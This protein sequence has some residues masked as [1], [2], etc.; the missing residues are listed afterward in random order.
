VL[1]RPSNRRP[2][3]R[4]YFRRTVVAGIWSISCLCKNMRYPAT[5]IDDLPILLKVFQLPG[6]AL[7][8]D[9]KAAISK[10]SYEN[11]QLVRRMNIEVIARADKKMLIDCSG[12]NIP[13]EISSAFEAVIAFNPKAV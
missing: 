12:E 11:F 9:P 2:Q 5:F 3:T 4:R 7:I 10:N 1:Q 6:D 13:D 8:Y